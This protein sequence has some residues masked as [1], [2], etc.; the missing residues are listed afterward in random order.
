MCEN[1]REFGEI[2][3]VAKSKLEREGGREKDFVFCL[4]WLAGVFLSAKIEL[5]RQNIQIEI[6]IRC[7]P[8][9][10]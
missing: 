9:E 3:L 8:A 4:F 1:G 7:S 2:F 6:P 10:T 5:C